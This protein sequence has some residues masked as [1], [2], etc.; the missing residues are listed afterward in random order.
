MNHFLKSLGI[1]LLLNSNTWAADAD[2]LPY[3]YLPMSGAALGKVFTLRA[4]AT[5]GAG[6][7][8]PSGALN[9][10]LGG[11]S[12]F[13]WRERDDEKDLPAEPLTLRGKD[14]AGQPWQV[15][16]DE[17]GGCAPTKVLQGDLD[18]DGRQDGVIV[19][20]TCGNGL[21]APLV[22]SIITFEA[23]GRPL[24]F[25]RSTYFDEGEAAAVGALRDLDG[26]GKAE[27]LEANWRSGY[28][29]VSA[30]QLANARWQAV[31]SPF[32]GQTYPQYTRFTQLPNH[33]ATTPPAAARWL[34]DYAN[35]TPWFN[36][37]L[38]SLQVKT[39]EGDDP[40]I[41]LQLR[42]ATGKTQNCRL[43]SDVIWVKETRNG[44]TIWGALNTAPA[45][46]M[47]RATKPT[48]LKLF[49][50]TDAKAC[51]PS[52]VWVSE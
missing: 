34:P 30:Y 41:T 49:G 37:Q 27:W 36:G 40:I 46:A 23:N 25:T 50:H 6:Q 32:A 14:Q 18:G 29:A 2:S 22:V 20:P 44:R 43:P 45:L 7:T 5:L 13:T 11:G 38:R 47:L 28:W 12:R 35:S 16:L 24:L 39:Q 33:R 42:D 51:S 10:T 3:A 8:P 15:S 31:S 26:D 48:A 17:V 4:V 19:R 9:V 21:A 52:M 1:L